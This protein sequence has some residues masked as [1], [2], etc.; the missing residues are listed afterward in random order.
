MN[1]CHLPEYSVLMSVY[2]N[3][4]AEYLNLAIKSMAG[5]AV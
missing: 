4:K 1:D 5:Q 3:D 2:K